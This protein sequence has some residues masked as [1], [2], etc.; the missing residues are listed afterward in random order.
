MKKYYLIVC[1]F[2]LSSVLLFAQ[3]SDDQ[4][5]RPLKDVIADVEKRFDVKIRYPEELVKDRMVTYAGWRFRGGDLEKTLTNI[6]SSHDIT[7]AKDGDK[8][9]KLQ[10]FQY[11]LKTVEEGKQ[12]LEYLASLYNNKAEWEKRKTELK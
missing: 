1:F 5:R 11:H 2:F 12:Q 9:Y 7:F 6:L 3:T 4:F 10:A 8:R